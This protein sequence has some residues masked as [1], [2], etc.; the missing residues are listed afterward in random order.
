MPAT[1]TDRLN[2]LT[3]STAIKPP[4]RVATTAN[5]TLSGLQTVAGVIL[6]DGDRVLVKDQDDA[7]ENGILLA[8]TSAW[9]R[10][11]DFNGTR[12]A[13][14]GTLILVGESAEDQVA[15]QLVTADPIVIGTSALSFERALVGNAASIS[16][17]DPLGL[18]D[19]LEA[20]QDSA[21][22]IT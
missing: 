14:R 10:A 8:N 16:L 5:I 7:T 12:D 17:T 4:C 13:V 9:T 19:S 20:I 3:T 11:P 6:E 18:F 15:Y 22:A 1:A 21:G 2:G